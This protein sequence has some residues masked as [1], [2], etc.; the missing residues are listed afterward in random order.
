MS[1]SKYY[2]VSIAKNI[3]TV[4]AEGYIHYDTKLLPVVR[5]QFQGSGECGVTL[6]C[7]SYQIHPDTEWYYL[8][9]S[10]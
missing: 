9:Q 6:R 5:L 1:P 10:C 8:L 2:L 3:L 4:S 7:Y